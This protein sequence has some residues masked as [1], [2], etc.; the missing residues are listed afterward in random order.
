MKKNFLYSLLAVFGML[1]ASC[2]QEEI[3]ST[4]D[5]GMGDNKVRLSVNI[6]DEALVSRASQS[7]DVEGYVMRCICQA[8]DANGALIEGFN[9]ITSVTNGTASFEF[10]APAGVANYLF[11]A[12]YVEGTDIEATKSA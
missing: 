9:Q 7:L 5:T 6:S 4:A 11:W 8:V 12:D 1:F 2:S 10:E 3:V